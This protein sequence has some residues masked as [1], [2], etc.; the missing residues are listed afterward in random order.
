MNSRT[1]LNRFRIYDDDTCR[2]F[3]MYW[4]ILAK[5]ELNYHSVNFAIKP[6]LRLHPF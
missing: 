5:H 1:A 4:I 3:Y 6:Q 2:P